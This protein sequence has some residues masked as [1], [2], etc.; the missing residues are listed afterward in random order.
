MV[1]QPTKDEIDQAWTNA[2]NLEG[3]GAAFSNALLELKQLVERKTTW[4][5]K[6]E[7]QFMLSL[8]NYLTHYG[9][10]LDKDRKCS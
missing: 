2:I 5:G 10:Q 1:T 4:V 9:V 3:S 6:E 7:V 8:K